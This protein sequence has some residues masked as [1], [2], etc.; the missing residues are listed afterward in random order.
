MHLEAENYFLGADLEETRNEEAQL[1]DKCM[2]LELKVDELL[3]QKGNSTEAE[4]ELRQRRNKDNEKL[5]IHKCRTK[6]KVLR[7]FKWEENSADQVLLRAV[8]GFWEDFLVPAED[9]DDKGSA[10]KRMSQLDVMKM[11]M[12]VTLNGWAGKTK[13]ES[14]KEFIRSKKYC[15][16]QMARSS[17]VNSTFNVRAASD[18]AKCDLT[19]KKYERGLLP[20][21]QTCRRVMQCVYNAAEGIGFSSFPVFRLFPWKR[22]VMCGAG[23]TPMGGVS[24]PVSTGMCTK[25][26]VK[27]IHFAKRRRHM[28]RG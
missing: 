5:R 19:R 17:D 12:E 3:Q 28:I 25:Y 22:M 9:G 23:A 2:Q 27:T 8:C 7:A 20:S 14:L 6:Q 4:K 18:I 26:I 16:I 15:P 21:D 10:K 11:W 13:K 1:K 24:R